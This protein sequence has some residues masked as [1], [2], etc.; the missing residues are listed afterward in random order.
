MGI[1]VIQCCPLR[2]TPHGQEEHLLAAK[3][4][5][6]LS[7]SSGAFQALQDTGLTRHL[8]AQPPPAVVTKL[9]QLDTPWKC[10]KHL[11][12]PGYG[13]ADGSGNY[14]IMTRYGLGLKCNERLAWIVNSVYEFQDI[15]S[16][17]CHTCQGR[18][19]RGCVLRNRQAPVMYRTAMRK[20]PA[21]RTMV[22]ALRK[23]SE[24]IKCSVGTTPL[25]PRPTNTPE[26]QKTG[27]SIHLTYLYCT[28]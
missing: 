16:P 28:Y 11:L 13:T 5:G 10:T 19:S 27:Q 25:R 2:F 4:R 22:V 7:P 18:I 15:D 23:P 6:T 21:H 17:R 8:S 3:V 9:L 20:Q 12:P 14:K 26:T 1:F 24:I